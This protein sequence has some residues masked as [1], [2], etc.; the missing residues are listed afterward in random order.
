MK[1]KNF[2]NFSYK[3]IYLTF[4]LIISF[5]AINL[6]ALFITMTGG[7]NQTNIGISLF[8]KLLNDFW[9]GLG[10][11]LLFL[12][13]YLIFYFIKKPVGIIF[14]KVLFTLIIIGQFALVKYNLTTHVNLG[15]DILG[16]SLNEMSTTV[17]A[18]G[19][20]SF[21]SFLPFIVLS[22]FFFG[23][24]FTFNKFTNERKFFA[25]TFIILL[26]FG[27][28]KLIF[29]EAS[30]TIYKNKLSFLGTDI[31]KY[32]LERKLMDTYNLTKKDEYPL[33]KSFQDSN[34]VLS[35]F[36]NIKEEKPNIV[37][38]MVEG[39]GSEF[40]GKGNYGGFT[41]FLDSLIPQSLFWENFVSNTGRTFGC[42]PSLLGS[43]PYGEKGFMELNPIP[44]HFSLI[45]VL[46]AND[47]TTS[48]YAGHQTNFDRLINF[49]EYNKVDHVINESSFGPEYVKTVGNSDGFSWGYPDSEIYKKTL[50]ELD[51][52]KMPRLDIVMTLTNHEPFEFAL[53]DTYLEKVYSLMNSEQTFKIDKQEITA[54]KD[55]FASLLY[56]DKSLENFMLEYAKRPE[57]NNTIFIITGDHRLI[58]IVQ[59]DKLCRFHV[60]LIIFSPMLKQSEK[61]KSV[62]SH[63]DVTPSLLS[64]L[65]NNYKFNNM[66]ETFWMSQGLDTARQFRNIHKIPLMRYKGAINDYIYKDHFYSSDE[67]YKINENFGTN[68]IIDENLHKTVSDSFLEFKKL[69]A[70]VTKKNRIFPDSLNIY[71]EPAVQFTKEHMA[72]IDT[73]TKELNYDQ[74]FIVA[75]DLAFN[76]KYEKARL[77]CDYILNEYPSYSDARTLKGRT[78]AWE[79]KFENAEEEL[80][81]VLKRTPYYEDGY[82]AL[83]DLYWWSSQDEKSINIVKEAK[84]N[85][86]KNI[87]FSFKL[88]QAYQRMNKLNEANKLMDSVLLL[89]PNNEL[90]KA[91]KESIKKL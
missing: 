86:I 76:K 41:P 4:S 38:I 19:S 72:I 48:F 28:S 27:S 44:S 14:I 60:P 13:L 71:T 81:N 67:L 66:K 64:F 47:Y 58:P 87:D 62:S 21:F 75:R 78:F 15:A 20:V 91:F 54:Y 10:I 46:K 40:V 11:G 55:I 22:M 49:L 80:L 68:K 56:T 85:G 37:I 57:Y 32:Q 63:W 12:P 23:I 50:S 88:A 29:S 74:I 83:L 90:Y 69:N 39:L 9:V 79:G 61:F 16:Y 70:Y 53:K 45:S 89:Y 59:K 34:D 84:E 6:F 35:P 65:M 8:Y 77:L 24:N 25:S 43:L 18:S 36:F 33:L 7:L 51:R 73:L 2:R 17:A 82:I 5:W 42:V 26:I 1:N 30:E 52:K 3:Y 31:Y